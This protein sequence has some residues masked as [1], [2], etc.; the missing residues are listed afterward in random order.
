VNVGVAAVLLQGYLT[1][2]ASWA[3]LEI[4]LKKCDA[5]SLFLGCKTCAK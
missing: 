5:C 2:A 3:Y 1:V 4:L